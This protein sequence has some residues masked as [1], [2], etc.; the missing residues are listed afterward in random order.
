[1]ARETKQDRLVRGMID[2]FTEH[3]HEFKGM[4]A[5]PS[6]KEADIERWGQSLI[7]SCLGFTSTNG[8][9]IRSQESKGKSRPDLV[10]YKNEIPVF[11]VEVKKLGFDLDKSDFRSGKTQLAQYLSQIGS[12]R[13]GVL[14][15]GYEWRLFDFTN[16]EAGGIEVL[17][18]D[19]R[20]DTDE[21]DLNKRAVEDLCWDFIDFHEAT[22]ASN[23]WVEFAKEA[24]AFSAES[25]ARALLSSEVLKL[26]ARI[27][28]GEHEFKANFELLS[29]RVF[30]L[31]N[32]GL[33]DSVGTWNETKQAELMKYLKTQKRAVRKKKRASKK[34]GTSEL[35]PVEN[36]DPS[37]VP[38]VAVTTEEKKAA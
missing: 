26:V 18:V 19:M 37:V 9:S 35:S 38:V 1:M 29:D 22:Y 3:M 23:E 2:N 15:N 27:I 24:T 8:Y 14:C 30:D 5:N 13:W 25:L 4:T 31:I 36:S 21:I 33:D 28:R 6:L 20:S 11:V 17:A 10:V 34:D 16:P 7:K 12:V 32:R